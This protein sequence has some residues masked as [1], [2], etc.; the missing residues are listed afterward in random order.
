MVPFKMGYNESK[1]SFIRTSLPF[2]SA[3]AIL[4]PQIHVVEKQF[5]AE[6]VSLLSGRVVLGNDM[7]KGALTLQQFRGLTVPLNCWIKI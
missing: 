4:Q 7:I 1:L 6:N 2:H 5:G 3:L